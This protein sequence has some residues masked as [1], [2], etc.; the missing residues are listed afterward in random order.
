MGAI[1]RSITQTVKVCYSYPDDS[2]GMF[3][4]G[5][6]GPEVRPAK[7]EP[8]KLLGTWLSKTY[9]ARDSITY[10]D[11]CMDDYDER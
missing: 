10:S 5:L 3:L 2:P 1:L 11:S 7:Q 8:S 4:N 9:L 6:A